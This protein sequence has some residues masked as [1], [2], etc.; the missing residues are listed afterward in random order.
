MVGR[1]IQPD[2]LWYVLIVVAFVA[3]ALAGYLGYVLYPRF[4]LPSVSGAGLL[5][6][7]VAAGIASFFSPCSFPLLVSLLGR[8]PDSKPDRTA[9][10]HPVRYG[11]ALAAGAAGFLIIFGLVTALAGTSIFAGV[12][13]TST[14][15]IAIRTVVGSLLILLGVMQLDWL[16]FSFRAADRLALPLLRAQAQERRDKPYRGFAMLGFAYPIAGFG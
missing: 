3:L 9:P 10:S 12:T 2:V 6:L 13:F 7:A 14:A 15:G 1:R 11:A 16:P 5:V 4:G 8:G